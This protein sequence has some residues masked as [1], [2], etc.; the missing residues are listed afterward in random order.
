MRKT[1]LLVTLFVITALIFTACK[2]GNDDKTGKPSKPTLSELKASIDKMKDSLKM[3]QKNGTKI[4]SLHRIELINRL[5][6]LYRNYPN[7]KLAPDCLFETHMIYSAM[8]APAYSSAYA[9]TLLKQ[10]PKFKERALVLESQGSNYD[11]FITPR[12]SAKVRYYYSMLLEEYPNL[13]KEKRDGIIKRL[14]YNNLTFDE[15]IGQMELGLQ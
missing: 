4:E 2:G 3:M 11:L 5:V 13:D 6:A 9:D 8:D 10:Y 7:D 1:Y 15:Y 14:K 12:D